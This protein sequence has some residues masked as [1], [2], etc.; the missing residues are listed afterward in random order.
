[1]PSVGAQ[2]IPT[3]LNKIY[4]WKHDCLLNDLPCD[5]LETGVRA[6]RGRVN[7]RWGNFTQFSLCIGSWQFKRYVYRSKAMHT[8]FNCPFCNDLL[9]GLHDQ[10][11]YTADILIATQLD[12]HLMV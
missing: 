10:G 11:L 2:S 6:S 7:V 3:K 9:P 4:Q 1:M 12:T 5:L 8:A